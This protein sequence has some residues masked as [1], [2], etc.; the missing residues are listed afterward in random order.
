MRGGENGKVF[1][2][3]HF[4]KFVLFSLKRA[5]NSSPFSE[6]R[7]RVENCMKPREER[8]IFNGA[9]SLKI[10]LSP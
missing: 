3:P 9:F 8:G 2:A 1:P 7:K 6:R 10:R 4:I 5:K